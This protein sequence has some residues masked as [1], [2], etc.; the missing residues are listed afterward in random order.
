LLPRYFED[1]KFQLESSPFSEEF[2]L[3]GDEGWMLDN[4]SPPQV[5]FEYAFDNAGAG[6]TEYEYRFVPLDG[7]GNVKLRGIFD[8]SVE[9]NETNQ[10]TRRK[11]RVYLFGFPKGT[12]R[13][14]PLIVRGKR[15][16][17]TSYETD[18]NLGIVVWL[19]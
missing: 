8:E 19:R 17:V 2:V 1:L 3:T 11:S 16:E 13:G 4:G 14:T 12:K 6:D 9:R 7:E 18:A 15:Y 5:E 10:S